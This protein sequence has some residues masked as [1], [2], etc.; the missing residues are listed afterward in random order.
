MLC[1]CTSDWYTLCFVCKLVEDCWT[2]VVV[3]AGK[4]QG[5]VDH[6]VCTWA[7]FA[8]D[9]R[10]CSPPTFALSPSSTLTMSRR[11]SRNSLNIRQNDALFEFENFKKRFLMANKQITRLN[12]TL[13]TRIEDLNAQVSTLYAENLRLRATEIAL[14]SELKRERDKS[15]KIMEEAETATLSLTKHFKFLRHSMDI[16][17]ERAESPHSTTAIPKATRPI[18]NPDPN[19]T[20]QLNKL[21]RPPTIPGIHEDDESPSDPPSPGVE[22][23]KASSSKPKPRLSASK[24]PLPSRALSPPPLPTLATII[25]IPVPLEEEL[26]PSTK[27]KTSRRQ[28]GSLKDTKEVERPPS[29]AFGSPI[30]TRAIVDE[31]EEVLPGEI[32]ED[33]IPDPAIIGPVISRKEAMKAKQPLKEPLSIVTD[34]KNAERKRR[35]DESDGSESSTSMGPRKSRLQDVT[36]SARSRSP[37]DLV[38]SETSPPVAGPSNSKREILNTPSPDQLPAVRQLPTPR[39]SS[40]PPPDADGGRATRTRKS[41]NY[42][43]PKLNTKM[44]K[45]EGYASAIKKRSSKDRTSNAQEDPPQPPRPRSADIRLSRRRYEDDEDD[46]DDDAVSD[47]SDG[48]DADSEYT[49]GAGLLKWANVDT[50]RKSVKR[51]GRRSV[52]SEP[53]PSGSRGHSYSL[54]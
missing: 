47:A 37:E 52:L 26:G 31:D 38:L 41:V 21:S 39:L 20:P 4:I 3:P 54:G 48:A 17:H 18:P 45:P 11:E 2:F 28:S 15:R 49:P 12:S 40:S 16:P 8:L 5:V 14:N 9:N 13:S 10:R 32:P 24:L 7:L 51:E 19:A 46:L 6:G 33:L 29:P 53:E 36:N 27:R 22:R 25:P 34:P 42:A 35:R 44:R 1:T 30:R 23:R 43:E 50:R